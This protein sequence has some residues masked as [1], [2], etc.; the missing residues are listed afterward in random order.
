MRILPEP[1]GPRS[2][3][4]RLATLA[5]FFYFSCLNNGFTYFNSNLTPA[6][7]MLVSTFS[8]K[9]IRTHLLSRP[10]RAVSFASRR[11]IEKILIES[12]YTQTWL[13]GLP[14]KCA[15]GGASAALKP[16]LSQRTMAQGNPVLC[17]AARRLALESSPISLKLDKKS[18]WLSK[19]TP[20]LKDK[21]GGRCS[22]GA[23][24][25]L[26]DSS[27]ALTGSSVAPPYPQTQ[28]KIRRWHSSSL[29]RG[30]GGAPCALAL[31]ARSHMNTLPRR[32][33]VSHF[34]GA[35]A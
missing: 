33:G 24:A 26:T 30:G 15:A 10:V 31:V 29:S 27:V 17:R 16:A 23:C 7:E 5:C 9:S 18:A 11:V 28:E 8:L 6:A 3:F 34:M 32:Q 4:R 12:S 20:L 1:R 2:R 14:G 35:A 21:G 22:G 13:A 19:R 25:A